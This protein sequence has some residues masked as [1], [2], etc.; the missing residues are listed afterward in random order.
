MDIV[1]LNIERAVQKTVKTVNRFDGHKG[2]PM[3]R[4]APID[5]GV[6]SIVSDMVKIINCQR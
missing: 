2:P 5:S 3:T 1:V 4:V 6:S